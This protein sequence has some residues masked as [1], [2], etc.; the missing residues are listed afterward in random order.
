MA[1]HA[2]DGPGRAPRIIPRD[3]HNV[4][5]KY[6][7]DN[8]LKV[9]NRLQGAGFEAYLVG[10][11]VRDLL[12]GLEPKDFDVATSARPEQ[13]RELFRNS[14]IIGRRFRLVHVRFGRE[15]IEVSTFRAMH[16]ETSEISHSEDGRI[17]RDNVFGEL[18]A[19]A[20]RRDF[21]VN[22]LYYTPAD[23][24]ILDFTG[25]MED[26]AARRLRIIGDADARYREDPV[27]MLRA[28][29]LASKLEFELDPDTEAP[30]GRLA[31]LLA[32]I[33]AARLF[34]EL[35]KLFLSGHALRSWE[36]LLDSPLLAP[37]LPVVAETLDAPAQTLIETAMRNTDQ[38]IRDGRPVTPGFLVAALLW[39]AVRQFAADI[40]A[41]SRRSPAA[42]LELAAAEAL[43]DQHQRTS[44]PRRHSQ[45]A[46]ETW[47]LQARLESRHRPVDTLELP[48]F[49][50][51]YDLL[52]LRAH[53]GEVD[54]ALVDWWTRFQQS[55]AELQAEMAATVPAPRKH[56]R[57]R[58][59][60][61]QTPSS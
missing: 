32:D 57:R 59:R 37:M 14:R 60:G 36:A 49:R 12:L 45:F 31:D 42:V 50:A 11:G 25:G 18:D 13:V 23:F 39:P 58:R 33:P 8:A 7:S 4:S 53:A 47:Q 56:R 51:A 3:E 54:Q 61:K 5:R 15:I 22:A 16:E 44:I 34:D 20:F 43:E 52:E 24:S 55:D 28:L 2:A 40:A 9:L 41:V 48:R 1:E 10:G 46:R 19:D 30:I 21:T 38:R 29:R 6:I 35:I 27:R 17:L 26:I